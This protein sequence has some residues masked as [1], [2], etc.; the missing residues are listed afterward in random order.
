MKTLNRSVPFPAVLILFFLSGASALIYETVWVR[1]LTLSF[2][3]SIHAL[4]A[5][6]AAFMF[7]LSLGAAILGRR[8][9]RIRNPLRLFAWFEIAVA[10]YAV[11]LYFILSAWLPQL[12]RVFHGALPDSAWVISLVRF[13]AAFALL[14]L[15]TTLMGGTLPI[16]GQMV[17]G[18]ANATGRQLGR[19]YGI[20]T[21]GAV[22]G[23]ALAG[24]FLLK[25]VGIFYT[26]LAAVALN[27][28]VG[29]IALA[30]SRH[31]RPD[32][33]YVPAPQPAEPHGT[34]PTP[35]SRIVHLAVF[36]SGYAAIAFQIMW[37]RTLLLYTHNSTYAFSTILIVFLGG[38]ALGSLAYARLPER[39]TSLRNLG[40][41]Q[42][43]LAAYVWWSIDLTGRLPD[44]LQ[45]VTAV[46]GTDRWISAMTTMFV[47]VALVVFLPTAITQVLA[48]FPDRAVTAAAMQ[49]FIQMSGGAMGAFAVSDLQAHLPLL[50]MPT[51]MLACVL[52]SASVFTLGLS[53][54]RRAP[55]QA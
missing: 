45:L 35:A 46:V 22:L 55:I 38:I 12:V 14:V 54:A 39:W 8:A 10:A 29:L 34:S 51:V 2:G 18:T 23:T 11:L 30:L 50:A 17:T 26:T 19:L 24:F 20:N 48:R 5:V 21:L 16:L 27:L 41:V 36:L 13:A 43:A 44:V 25:H 52:L 33:A 15:P 49:G 47:A 9:R 3:I 6:L 7:G 37:N 42:I 1:Q 28:I 40:C 53:T 4:S 31:A 32:R